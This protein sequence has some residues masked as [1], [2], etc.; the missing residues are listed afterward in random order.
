M[1]FS[2]VAYRKNQVRGLPLALFSSGRWASKGAIVAARDYGLF[3]SVLKLWRFRF[4]TK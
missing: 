2:L 1:A 3:P 4:D